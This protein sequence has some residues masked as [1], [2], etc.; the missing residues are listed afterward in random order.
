MQSSLS[1]VAR[2]A[3]LALIVSLVFAGNPASIVAAQTQTT[4]IQL[5]DGSIC[6]FA[7]PSAAPAIVNGQTVTYYCGSAP[8]NGQRVIFGTPTFQNGVWSVKTGIIVPATGGGFTLQSSDTLS[9]DFVQATL[10]DGT[11]CTFAGSN[12]VTV[13]GQSLNYTCGQPDTGLLGTFNTSNPLWTALR[14]RLA[15]SS[16]NFSVTSRDTVGVGNVVGQTH[17]TTSPTPTPVSQQATSI[18]LPDG[19]LCQWAGN[20]AQPV[21]NGQRVNYTCGSAP[22]NATNVIL[23]TPTQQNGVWTVMTGV[24]GTVNNQPTLQSS[25]TITMSLSKVSL[26]DNTDCTPATGTPVTVEGQPMNYTCGRAE[27][28]LLGDFN[29]S[30][31]LWTAVK[32]IIATNNGTTSVTDRRTLGITSVV[33]ANA[34][35]ALQATSIQLPDGKVCQSATGATLSFNGQ[36]VTYNCGTAPDGSMTVILGNPT[37]QNGSLIVQRGVVVPGSSG[38]TLRSSDSLTLNVSNVQ[39]A[40]GTNCASTGQGATIAVNGQRLNY[41]C[42]DP[43]N[44]LIGDF[45]ISQ[46][47]WTATRVQLTGSGSNITVTSQTTVQ[48]R[49]A[50][51]QNQTTTGPTPAPTPVPQPA[52]P[53]A[54]QAR[55]AQYFNETMF[56]VSDTFWSFFQSRGAIETF[57]FP[58]SRQFGF[59]GCQVQ[60]F[61]RLITQQCANS[62]AIALINMLDPEI[63]PYTVVNSSVFPAADDS[64]KAKT[65]VPGTPG[66]DQAIIDFVQ[67]TAPDTF[68]GQPVNFFQTFNSTGGLE[69]WGAPISNPAY[70]PG[71]HNFIY[72]RFQR[73]I[74][75]YTV[76]QGTRGI[77]LADYLKAIMLGPTLA[78]QKGASLPADLNEESKN[79]AF[80]TQY[81]PGATGWLCRPQDMPGSDLTFAFEAG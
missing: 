10:V 30:N 53:A 65:P 13:E 76:G 19:T 26:V 4:S 39:L 41:T 38:P 16:P 43:M 22:N 40:D 12:A 66:Y 21:F 25:Q 55:D 81:C 57:G 61:Q 52:Q 64:I 35:A 2:L 75:H 14:V 50:V 49:T 46:P 48:L 9:L 31:P 63:F 47:V 3:Q 79:S 32:V 1:L 69:I 27:E 7:G 15:G 18:K 11:N 68:D 70:D 5:P 80:H 51:T 78:Q 37:F 44:G 58:V 59:L 72:Q 74:M 42:G 77:L 23:G 8:N 29:T 60:I 34:S 6:Q 36:N 71:N 73:G 33:G 24:V 62:S 28:G 54:P 45:N 17:G 56:R 20:G 67:A